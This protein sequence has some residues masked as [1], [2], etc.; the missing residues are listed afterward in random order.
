MAER[1]PKVTKNRVYHFLL[2]NGENQ[3]EVCSKFQE[4]TFLEF[5]VSTTGNDDPSF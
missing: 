1:S 2:S 3:S 4:P 5:D